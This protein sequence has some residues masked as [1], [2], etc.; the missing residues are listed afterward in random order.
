MQEKLLSIL[1]CPRCR[2]GLT[3]GSRRAEGETPDQI[4]EGALD[5]TGCG[6]RYPVVRGIPRLLPPKHA[7]DDAVPTEAQRTASHFSMEFTTSELVDNDADISSAADVEYY[8]YSRTGVDPEIYGRTAGSFY[9]TGTSHD[10]ESYRPDGSFLADKLVLD[11]GCGPGRF[12]TVAAQGAAHVV[13]LD[14]GE[15]V[16]RAAERC[17]HLPNTDIVQGSVLQPPFKPGVF[18]YV[19]SVGV[20]HH[21]ADPRLGCL[22]LGE[23]VSPGGAMS[24]WVYPPEYWGDPFRRVINRQVHRSLSRLDPRKSLDVCTRWLYPLGRLQMRLSE[25]RWT[26]I[27]GASVFALTVPRHPVREVMIST[28]YDRFCPPLIS[29]H[30]YGEVAG[31]LREAQ[32][33][34]VQRLPVP[35]SLFARKR[36]TAFHGPAVAPT[37]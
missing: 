3:V 13:G 20:L 23:L 31:W 37:G 7:P 15:H 32:F 34:E 9:R 14:F 35:T 11:A 12:T 10:D 22:K 29:T 28:I 25:R 6:S 33:A 26:K 16:E 36:E 17:R 21:T 19:F 1:A 2:S 27:V 8:F 30:T 24:V 4:A 18:D 5:C